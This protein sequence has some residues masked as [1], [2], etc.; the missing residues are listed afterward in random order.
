MMDSAI[1]LLFKSYRQEVLRYLFA[2]QGKSFHVR[3][4]ARRTSTQPGT[5]NKELVRLASAGLVKKTRLGN[6]LHYQINL[7]SP[8]YPELSSIFIKCIKTEK[9]GQAHE[10]KLLERLK[11]G[12]ES[13]DATYENKI[14]FFHSSVVQDAICIRIA[15]VLDIAMQSSILGQ[16]LKENL[17]QELSV[18]AQCKEPAEPPGLWVAVTV[19][20]PEF[21]RL[22]DN[23][24]E[25]M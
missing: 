9:K 20:L 5:L 1:D 25:E 4:L 19:K 2:H 13:I 6:Q 10:R 15:R 7:T 17:Q 14:Q 23:I 21:K 18:F 8:I 11:A 22:I 12:L 16:S 3:E 24:L